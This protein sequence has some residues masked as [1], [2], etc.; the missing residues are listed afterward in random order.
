VLSFNYLIIYL[1][2]QHCH[3][4]PFGLLRACPA[5]PGHSPGEPVEGINSAKKPTL[6]PPE[7][8]DKLKINSAKDL[9][10]L[11][12]FATGDT[13]QNDTPESVVLMDYK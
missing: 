7:P 3:S 8:F 11:R 12:R 13:P 2:A 10:I 9:E 4:E 5:C 6:W 1:H